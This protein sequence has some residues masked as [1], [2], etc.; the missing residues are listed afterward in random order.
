MAKLQYGD[1]KIEVLTLDIS[2]GGISF[3]VPNSI[4]NE[5]MDV[6]HM[7]ILLP[8]RISNKEIKL[9]GVLRYS[10]AYGL[11]NGEE[12]SRIGLMFSKSNQIKEQTAKLMDSNIERILASNPTEGPKG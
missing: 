9:T 11:I 12:Y 2:H 6:G 4:E 3:L 5:I 8:D 10:T 7:E 1:Q